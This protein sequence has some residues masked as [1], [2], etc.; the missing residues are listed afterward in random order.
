LSDEDEAAAP[1]APQPKQ[2]DLLLKRAVEILN[3]GTAAASSEQPA[4][5]APAEPKPRPGR[6]DILTPLNVPQPKP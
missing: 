5:A 6:P 2:E 3:K 4:S 1:A